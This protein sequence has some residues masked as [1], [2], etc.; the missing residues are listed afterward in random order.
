MN[1]KQM[2]AEIDRL[3]SEAGLTYNE[4]NDAFERV[5]LGGTVNIYNALPMGAQVP[6]DGKSG[7][8]KRAVQNFS[9]EA[10][11]VTPKTIPSHAHAH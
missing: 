9:Q 8:L 6:S 5:K 7:W 4:V 2:K 11:I 3:A 1:R 10:P